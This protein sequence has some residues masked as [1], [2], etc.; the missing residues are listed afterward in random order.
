MKAAIF[1]VS[2]VVSGFCFADAP[3]ASPKPG[4]AAVRPAEHDL[5]GSWTVRIENARHQVVTTM[6]I[7]FVDE[8]ASSCMGGQWKRVVVTSHTSS[9]EKFFP[10]TE[11]L[12]YEL[13]ND[14][15]VI[16]RNEVCDA[17]LHLEGKIGGD[18][19]RGEYIGFGLGG[20]KRRGFF[21]M[22]KGT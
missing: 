2:A 12:S 4:D 16:G 18:A 15:I 10:V 11:P 20:G 13:T 9:D 6:T 8:V 14:D 7:R 5:T 19:A 1:V 3:T 17:Y 21:S 22:T